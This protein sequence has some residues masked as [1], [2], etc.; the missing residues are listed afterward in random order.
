MSKNNNVG[1]TLTNN[2]N[3]HESINHNNLNSPGTDRKIS[4]FRSYPASSRMKK[5]LGGVT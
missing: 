1:T 4:Q 3:N 5:D 2:I